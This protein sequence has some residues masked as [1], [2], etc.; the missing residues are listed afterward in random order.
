M[1][2][3]IEHV[4]ESNKEWVS[5][6]TPKNIGDILNTMA[7]IPHMKRKKVKIE[8]FAANI[9]K[10]GETNF[11][12]IVDQFMINDYKLENMAK[13]GHSG[14]FHLSWH[15]TKT[16]K[17]YKILIDIKQYSST[18]PTKEIVK[19][20]SDLN[21][22]NISGGLFL[23][24]TSKICGISKVIDLKNSQKD[25]GQIVPCIFANIKNPITI[26]EVI[27]LL[28]HTIE[29][30]DLHH[31]DIESMNEL[32]HQV[33]K[34][35]DNIEMITECRDVLQSSKSEIEK[36]LNNIMYKL[37]S[38]EYSLISKINSINSTLENKLELDHTILDAEIKEA[39]EKYNK[40][41][42]DMVQTI[43]S[44]FGTYL[45]EGIAPFLYSIFNVG[46]D[47]SSLNLPKKTWS[48]IKGDHQ[49][50]IKISKGRTG[51][52]IPVITT[53]I[54]QIVDE[55]KKSKIVKKLLRNTSAG[56]VIQ[57]IPD[58]INDIILICQTL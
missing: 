56:L 7:L 4:N 43:V 11:E 46:W 10:E 47:S 18:V 14:D 44:S 12:N 20:Y 21:V 27:K 54:Q 55:M 39:E 41:P 53:D 5:N 24:L 50:T 36:N 48:L 45:Q 22:N 29:I 13:T 28:F 31:N 9:G 25:N 38:C 51:I 32:V 17:I 2:Q 58:T 16:N 30:K 52:I 33:N 57:I 23:S 26:V 8:K 40:Q 1:E 35:N 19:F 49:I 15:S 37:M 34:L 6:L 42:L 3:I